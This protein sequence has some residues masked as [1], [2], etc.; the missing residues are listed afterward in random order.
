MKGSWK[1]WGGRGETFPRSDARSVPSAAIPLHVIPR[2][3]HTRRHCCQISLARVSVDLQ[4][5]YQTLPAINLEHLEYRP[6]SMPGYSKPLNKC[7]YYVGIMG[8]LLCPW[9]AASIGTLY[10]FSCV[11][12]ILE[13][14][15]G[16]YPYFFYI[17]YA[18]GWFYILCYN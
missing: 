17:K 6:K 1:F 8:H 10:L 5:I 11:Q 7:G 13:C 12:P 14:R 2:R 18:G 9:I 3:S 4:K 16:G 15:R